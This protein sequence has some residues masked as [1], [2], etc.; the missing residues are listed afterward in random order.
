M[1]ITFWN[2]CH[3][4]IIAQKRIEAKKKCLIDIATTMASQSNQSM[5]KNSCRRIQR[6]KVQEHMKTPRF[7]GD[8]AVLGKLH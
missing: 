1:P 4:F 8:E 7:S 5:F 3:I 6:L 2:Q